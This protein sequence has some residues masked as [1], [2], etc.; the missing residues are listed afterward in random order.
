MLF[1]LQ[2]LTRQQLTDCLSPYNNAVRKSIA[3]WHLNTETVVVCNHT[4]VWRPLREELERIYLHVPV[5][6]ISRN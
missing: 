5:P 3:T 2:S 4:V 1:I 6:Y